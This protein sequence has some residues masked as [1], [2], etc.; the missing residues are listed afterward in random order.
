LTELKKSFNEK[1]KG[2]IE[3]KDAKNYFSERMAQERD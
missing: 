1:N 2:E 3:K